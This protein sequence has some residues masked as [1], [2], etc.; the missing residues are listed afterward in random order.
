[1]SGADE[2]FPDWALTAK[3]GFESRE[4]LV[5]LLESEEVPDLFHAGFSH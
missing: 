2:V 5:D 1:M 3:E 4:V